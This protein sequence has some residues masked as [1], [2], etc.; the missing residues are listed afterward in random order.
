ML[1]PRSGHEQHGEQDR[2]HQHHG[3][4]VRLD[5]NQDHRQQRQHKR[6]DEGPK[7]AIVAAVAEIPGQGQ[8]IGQLAQFGRL[9]GQEPMPT[10]IQQWA[11]LIS[12]GERQRHHISADVEQHQ[13]DKND[14][15]EPVADCPQPAVVHQV[16]SDKPGDAHDGEDDLLLPVAGQSSSYRSAGLGLDRVADHVDRQNPC[17]HQEDRRWSAGRF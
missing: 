5:Q 8:N 4:Q 14:P 12:R 6:A 3:S 1:D 16:G 10:L 11:P 15:I 7:T 17:E 2:H 9:D 13:Q